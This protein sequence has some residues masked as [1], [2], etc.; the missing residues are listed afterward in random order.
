MLGVAYRGFTPEYRRFLSG[1]EI[2]SLRVEDIDQ[3]YE[4]PPS[5]DKMRFSIAAP[6]VNLKVSKINALLESSLSGSEH[7]SSETKQEPKK[8][9][10]KKKS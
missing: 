1:Y 4:P 3:R 8:S 7:E 10:H 9:A 5:K 6:K 2:N